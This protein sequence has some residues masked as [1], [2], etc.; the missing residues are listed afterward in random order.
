MTEH[1]YIVH[2]SFKALQIL[3][4]NN[5]VVI[6]LPTQTGHRTPVLDF[7]IFS[8]FKTYRRNALNER[9]LTSAGAGRNDVHTLCEF[10]HNA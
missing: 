8:P 9:L 5:I 4:H 3:R 2:N 7:C 6:A 1:G 10:V